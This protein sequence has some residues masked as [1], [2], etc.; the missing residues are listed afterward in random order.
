[1]AIGKWI[2]FLNDSV[3]KNVNFETVDGVQRGGRLSGVTFR[4]FLLN[5]KE[6][7]FPTEIELNGDPNDRVPIERILRMEV[8]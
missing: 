6:V 2:D 5:K 4:S 8:S 1:M 3:E 7:K